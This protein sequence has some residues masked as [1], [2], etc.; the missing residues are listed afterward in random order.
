MEKYY[1][2]VLDDFICE[3]DC[4]IKPNTKIGS[5]GCSKCENFIE[6]GTKLF[7][8]KGFIVCEKLNKKI[9]S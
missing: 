5:E 8:K 2:K 7:N 3:E 1:Y 6:G 4:P 9:L